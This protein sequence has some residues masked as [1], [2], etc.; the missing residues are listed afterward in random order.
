MREQPMPSSADLRAEI[1]ALVARHAR[2]TLNAATVGDR[3]DLYEAGMTSMAS[4][5]LMLALEEYFNIEFPEHLLQRRTFSSIAAISDAV[6]AL[7][8]ETA[9]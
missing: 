8:N 6:S 5:N 4:V 9:P 7:R 3:A 1:R 2:T